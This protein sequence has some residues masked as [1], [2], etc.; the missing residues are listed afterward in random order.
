MNNISFFKNT[1]ITREVILD[2]FDQ[3]EGAG[4]PKVA[5]EN[6]QWALMRS[7]DNTIQT[8]VAF[9]EGQF[10]GGVSFSEVGPMVKEDTCWNIASVV[11][12]PKYRERGFA[13]QLMFE[14]MKD[15]PEKVTTFVLFTLEDTTL[16]WTKLGAA[17]LSTECYT[18]TRLEPRDYSYY[19]IERSALERNC[20]PALPERS[21]DNL[22][23]CRIL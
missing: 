20:A 11:V 16:F 18:N 6:L 10:V 9:K 2:A 3:A 21:H 14:T 1:E 17:P 12:M 23:L 4:V 7:N 8:V 13:K 19:M 5:Y 15:I 22:S